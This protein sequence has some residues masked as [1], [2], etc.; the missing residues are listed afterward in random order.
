[1]SVAAPK[2]KPK[3]LS[4]LQL[5]VDEGVLLQSKINRLTE[6][7][8]SIKEKCLPHMREL[9]G[10]KQSSEFAVEGGVCKYKRDE[11][12]GFGDNFDAARQVCGERFTELFREEIVIKPETRKIKDLLSDGDSQLGIALRNVTKLNVSEAVS[13]KPNV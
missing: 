9:A 8:K 2:T 10:E 4:A 7:L 12:V 5:L 11:A 13:F 1:M 6:K 3:K